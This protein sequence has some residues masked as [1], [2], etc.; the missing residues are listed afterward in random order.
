MDEV[1]SM[2][3]GVERDLREVVDAEIRRFLL[4]GYSRCE[5]VDNIVV[6]ADMFV[7]KRNVV[8]H[9]LPCTVYRNFVISN[10]G[11]HEVGEARCY[12]VYG[13]EAGEEDMAQVV[14]AEVAGRCF[15]NWHVWEYTLRKIARRIVEEAEA[16]E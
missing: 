3:D 10:T 2:I 14:V 12:I 1:E 9:G 16:G 13:G 5:V 8:I 15:V 7:V 6:N 4:E 11:V